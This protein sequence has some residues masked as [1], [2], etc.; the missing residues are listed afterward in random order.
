ML[1]LTVLKNM[2]KAERFNEVL[3]FC[4]T[5]VNSSS[6]KEVMTAALR[7]IELKETCYWPSA[8]AVQ[9]LAAK[10]DFPGVLAEAVINLMPRKF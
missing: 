3:S 5:E 6:A 9:G 8:A 7:G 4:L 2:T 10:G 1:N